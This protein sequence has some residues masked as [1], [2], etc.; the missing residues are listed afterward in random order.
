M[1]VIEDI[2]ELQQEVTVLQNRMNSAEQNISD[3]EYDVVHNN[4]ELL[5][6]VDDIHEEM[7]GL[8]DEDLELHRE[9]HNLG[10]SV[11]NRFATTNENIFNITR[12]VNQMPTT[13]VLS[14]TEYENL[15]SIQQGVM[16][17]VYEEE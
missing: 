1:S 8:R 13:V 17:Y 7:G 15:P 2:Q 6:D 16:Y 9:I 3:V 12:R 10:N 11:D 14:E 5:D 4:N